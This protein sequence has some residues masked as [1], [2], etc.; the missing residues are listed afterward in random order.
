MSA[1]RT[2]AIQRASGT[3]L[4]SYDDVEVVPPLFEGLLLKALNGLVRA[5]KFHYV[6]RSH[7]SY[8]REL[9][10]FVAHVVYWVA[11]KKE[12][13]PNPVE[14]YSSRSYSVRFLKAATHAL[15]TEE[16]YAFIKTDM[17]IWLFS[18]W[19]DRVELI[20]VDR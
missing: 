20:G 14:D 9:G 16:A 3:E 1:N 13:Y 2:V 12:G 8:H 4:V 7:L 19:L 18:L 5:P 11:P 6:R 10:E 17:E 15:E